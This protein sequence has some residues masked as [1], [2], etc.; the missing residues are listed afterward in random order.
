MSY[1]DGWAALNLEMPKRVPRTEYSAHMHWDL[2]RSVTGKQVSPQSSDSE[3]TNAGNAF[4]KAWNYDYMWTTG[5]GSKELAACHTSMG[6][7]EY[8]S[9]G[10]DRNDTLFCPFS[11]PE[12]ALS[13]DPLETYEKPD[14]AELKIRFE[15]HYRNQCDKY[16]DTVNSAGIYITLVSGLI[17]IFGWDMMLMAMGTDPDRFGTVT[18]R[19]A[20]WIQSYFDVLAETTV[21]VA[22]VHDDIVWTSGPFCSPEWYRQYVFPHY[23]DFLKPLRDSGKKIIFTS[24]GNYTMFIDDIAKAGVD[25]FVMEPT[26]DMAYIAENYGKTHSFIGNADTRILLNGD[27]ASIRTEVKRCMDIGKQCP[28]FFM[29]VGNHIPPN[30]PVNNALYYNRV[31]EEMSVR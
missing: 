21:P 18:N 4:V 23:H 6:H 22:M 5:I 9:G 12:E 7:A 8:A 11:S 2:I 1:E 31:Y 25:G 26:T 29:A 24:D 14:P 27:P 10:T 28:G 16:P 30:T 19:Y 20:E 3:K 13:F 15:Q 17:D